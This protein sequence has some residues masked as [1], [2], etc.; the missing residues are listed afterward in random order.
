[1]TVDTEV[2]IGSGNCVRLAEDVFDQDDE[3][4]VVVLLVD[5]PPADREAIVRRAAATCPTRAITIIED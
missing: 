2:C 5:T 3:E 4:G 1:V